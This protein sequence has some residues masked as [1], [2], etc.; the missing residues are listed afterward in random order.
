MGESGIRDQAGG[1][2]ILR[3]PTEANAHSGRAL[4]VK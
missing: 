2:P 3:A 4:D 1:K